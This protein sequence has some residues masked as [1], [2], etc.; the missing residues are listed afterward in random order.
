MIS[1]KE[2]KKIKIKSRKS[3]KV[4]SN[5][6]SSLIAN[7]EAIAKK[8]QREVLESDLIKVAKSTMKKLEKQLDVVVGEV[9]AIYKEEIAILNCLVPMEVTDVE[10]IRTIDEIIKEKSLSGNRAIGVLMKDLKTLF[11]DSLNPATASK[12]IRERI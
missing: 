8:E 4:L 1:I 7:A 6:Y 5:A 10:L 2:L 9:H 12:L 3:N 11:G